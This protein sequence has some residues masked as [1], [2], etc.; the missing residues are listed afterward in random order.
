TELIHFQNWTLRVRPGTGKRILLLIHG[1]TGDENSMW[2]FAHNFPADYWIIAPR[3]PHVASKRGYS[4]R[5]PVVPGSWPSIENMRSSA[6]GLVDLLGDWSKANGLDASTFD[7]AGFSQGG[8]MTFT[9]GAL[10][11]DRVGKMAILAGFAPQGAEQI[12][13]PAQFNGKNIF[14][15]HG[16]LDELVPI[17]MARR[18]IQMLENAGAQVTYCESEIG[19]KL[20]AE[21]LRALETYLA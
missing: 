18:S 19:H 6:D 12:L 11:P 1:W 16:T 2:I 15:A 7:V 5:S 8:A 20:G 13:A 17:E 4:W 14:V 10:Y 21:C 9:L 3:A